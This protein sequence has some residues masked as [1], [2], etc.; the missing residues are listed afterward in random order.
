[1][2]LYRARNIG[3]FTYHGDC[4]TPAFHI[5]LGKLSGVREAYCKCSPISTIVN[6]LASSM[7]N[8]KW[9]IVDDSN[10]DVSKN[11]PISRLLKK[12]NPLQ[13]M[14]ELIKQVDIYRNLYG[15]TYIYAV[16]P[17]GYSDMEDATALWAINPERIEVKYKKD[18]VLYFSQDIEDII[19]K[20]VITIAGKKIDVDPR[21][22]LQ[23]KDSTLDLIDFDSSGCSNRLKGLEYEIKNIVQAQEAIYSLNKD[24]GAQGIIT[25]KSN[26]VTGLIPMTP[27]EK[28]ELQ[29]DMRNTYGLSSEQAKYIITDKD[30]GW[31]QMSFSVRDLMLFE[32][33]EENLKSISNAYNY[34]YELL[35]NQ[36][37][38]T[39]ANRN[40]AIKYL[41]QDNIIPASDIYEEK[42]TE[43]LQLEN[44]TIDIDFSHIEYLKEAEKEKSEAFF[45]MN[46]ALQMAYKLKIITREEYREALDMEE[47]PKGNTFYDGSN[48][49]GKTNTQQGANN[50]ASEGEGESNQ[51]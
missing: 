11:Y 22:I 1:M 42:F 12:P 44:A 20:Y 21:H 34:A 7:A 48:E 15:V 17:E 27:E 26:D 40:E 45:K 46:Q 43:F 9:W 31:I 50:E 35:A 32:G 2:G 18:G 10:N 3:F 24:R 29:D 51:G 49:K 28:K 36:K 33:M 38:S 30:L 16:I 4:K 13:S 14:T 23:I 5:E 41:Y 25:N 8:G 39:Y 19:E 37:G 47:K 6:R